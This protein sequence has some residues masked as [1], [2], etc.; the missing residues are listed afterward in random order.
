[1]FDA[2]SADCRDLS[3][4]RW[5]SINLNRMLSGMHVFACLVSLKVKP[6]FSTDRMSAHFPRSVQLGRVYAM[7]LPFISG[8]HHSL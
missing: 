1:M 7:T 4:A 8:I 5:S 3:G 2:M 6:H